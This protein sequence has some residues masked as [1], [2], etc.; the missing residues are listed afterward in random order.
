MKGQKSDYKIINDKIANIKNDFNS[1][2]SNEPQNLIKNVLKN[3]TKPKMKP[4]P[5]SNYTP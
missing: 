4:R 5:N 3:N 1:K 2:I